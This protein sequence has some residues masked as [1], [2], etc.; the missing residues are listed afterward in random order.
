MP[1]SN[2]RPLILWELRP[3][4]VVATP[5]ASLQTP[6]LGLC[7]EQFPL[8]NRGLGTRRSGGL[9]V[10]ICSQSVGKNTDL[11][12]QV[13]TAKWLFSIPALPLPCAPGGQS[14]AVRNSLSFF[15]SST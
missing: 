14:P 8:P 4:L 5:G 6:S 11:R 7:W 2:P 10:T 12:S 13:D 15:E 3:A 1:G 9:A